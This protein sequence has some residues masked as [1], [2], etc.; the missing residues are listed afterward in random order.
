ML[1]DE[2]ER[3]VKEVILKCPPFNFLY[4]PHGLWVTSYFIGIFL[5]SATAE[6]LLYTF[7]YLNIK[8]ILKK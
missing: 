5:L 6:I 4:F 3:Q 8:Q 2:L 7:K 1:L